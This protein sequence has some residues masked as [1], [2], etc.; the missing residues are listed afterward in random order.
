MCRQGSEGGETNGENHSIM[1]KLE[2]AKKWKINVVNGVW[3]NELYL[4]NTLALARPIGDRYLP[5]DVQNHFYYDP[6]LTR[7]YMDQWKQLINLPAETIRQAKLASPLKQANRVMQQLA[8][9]R[10]IRSVS[11]T[12]YDRD[13]KIPRMYINYQVDYNSLNDWCL[14]ILKT[15]RDQSSV[16]GFESSGSEI[17]WVKPQISI[18]S[19]MFTGIDPKEVAQYQK[20]IN[21]DLIIRI[22]SYGTQKVC[23]K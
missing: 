19:V 2:K 1:S 14:K 12:M 13:T 11:P 23:S 3:L 10:F 20:V 15:D 6:L 22:Y 21:F 4:G 16:S 8:V 5:L 18:P 9:P 17:A 7:E